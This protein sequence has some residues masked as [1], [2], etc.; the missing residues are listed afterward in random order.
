MWSRSVC[1]LRPNSGN[2]ERR[3]QRLR[4]TAA[5]PVMQ[6]NKDVSFLVSSVVCIRTRLLCIA[7]LE[8]AF[9]DVVTR[10]H[11]HTMFVECL[12][13]RPH[14]LLLHGPFFILGAVASLGYGIGLLPF[15][16]A[17]W[18]WIGNITIIGVIVLSSVPELVLGRYRRNRPG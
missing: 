2:D 13:V 8:N 3:A 9:V 7:W 16:P 15:G 11:G 18:K 14:S 4:P 6:R 1:A 5:R 10:V 17:G 12:A